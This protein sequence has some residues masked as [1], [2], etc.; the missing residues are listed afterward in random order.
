M[1]ASRPAEGHRLAD[2]PLFAGLSRPILDELAASCRIRRYPQGQV[3]CHE[4]DPGDSLIVLEAGPLRISRFTEGGREAVLAVIEPPAAIGELSLIDGEPRDAT[5][6][7]QR[8]VQVRLLPRPTFLA[9]LEREPAFAHGV[10][11]SL[12]ALVRLGNARHADTVGLD[13]TGR[14]AKWLLARG[15]T[16]GRR[17]GRALSIPLGRSQGELAAELGMT[18]T[19]LNKTLTRLHSLGVLSVDADQIIVRR[20]EALLDLVG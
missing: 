7:A 10:L 18:R 12:A 14:L 8:A 16:H 2:V 9:L 1:V 5:I 19:S 15:A 17:D 11:R 13:V 4:G 20:P 3:L 6:T